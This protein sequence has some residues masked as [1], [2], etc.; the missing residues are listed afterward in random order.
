M[1]KVIDELILMIHPVVAG[2]GKRLF[3][4]GRSLKRMRLINSRI[5]GSGVAFL[6]Y[7]PRHE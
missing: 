1:R 6:T 2:H 7:T 3:K 5:T 4:D